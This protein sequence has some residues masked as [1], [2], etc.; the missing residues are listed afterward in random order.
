[1][2]VNRRKVEAVVTRQ[3]ILDG[4]QNYLRQHP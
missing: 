3:E 1:M 4:I 2:K